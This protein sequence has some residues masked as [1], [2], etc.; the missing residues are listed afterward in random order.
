MRR[1]LERPAIAIIVS[2]LCLAL[3]P[4]SSAEV[5][6]VDPFG[7][8]DFPTIQA[9]LDACADGDVIE[10]TGGVFR[11]D[12]NRDL[13]F[14]GKAILLCA[15]AG[16]ARTAGASNGPARD[17]VLD[18]QGSA[19]EPHRGM[20]FHSGEGAGSIVRG[21]SIDGGWAQQ[22]A[23]VRCEGAAAPTFIDCTFSGHR[24]HSGAAVWAD[25]GAAFT[26]C[27]FSGNVATWAGGGMVAY[28]P[29]VLRDCVFQGNR[30]SHGG[31]L[32]LYG[33]RGSVEACAFVA[34]EATGSGGGVHCETPGAP[35]FAG[36]TLAGN[37]AGS[38]GGGIC[39]QVDCTPSLSGCTLVGNGAPSGGG[40]WA[41]PL[42]A[43]DLANTLI[44][45]GL[46]GEAAVC[47]GNQTRLVCCD[48]FGN[49]GGDWVG[50][51]AGQLGGGGNLCADP[52]FCDPAAGDYRLEAASPCAPF[53]PPNPECDRIGAHPVGCG[54]TAVE[55][56]SWGSLKRIFR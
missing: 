11:G 32:Y 39:V 50:H 52:L 18:C 13:D 3:P 10:L 49:A 7:T 53:S 23:G 45:F 47:L 43:V 5:Y 44:A 55:S 6:G 40:L 54:S 30:A 31:G 16:R 19:A 38:I 51:V 41:G 56:V 29:V 25:A 15:Q 4:G 26:G 33:S 42:C 21:I 24:A 9:A 12:G 37:T 20:R 36:C 35:A 8:G 34:N 27:A 28:G 48:L 46:A 22:G 1:I 14:L 2:G 17:C